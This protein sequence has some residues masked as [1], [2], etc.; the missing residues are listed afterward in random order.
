MRVLI[1]A[2]PAPSHFTPMVP[3]AWALRAAGHEVLVM[4]Q[5]DITEPAVTAGLPAVTV[6]ER[7]DANEVIASKLAAGRRPN[8]SGSAQAGPANPLLLAQPWLIHAKYLTQQYLALAREW[9]PDL[10]LSDP[11]E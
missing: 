4:G 1:M 11:L 7:Y 3:L 10:I 5:P 8:Q 2:T 6:G 9:Q